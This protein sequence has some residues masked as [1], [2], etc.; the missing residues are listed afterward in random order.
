MHKYSVSCLI[1]KYTTR[2]E[3]YFSCE[4]KIK[5]HLFSDEAYQRMRRVELNELHEVLKMPRILPLIRE[6][7]GF[8]G[9]RRFTRLYYSTLSLARSSPVTNFFQNQTNIIL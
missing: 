5:H 8:Y 2:F 1:K 7:S 4:Q 6:F 3:K 9:K